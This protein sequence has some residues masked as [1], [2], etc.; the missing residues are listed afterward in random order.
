MKVGVVGNRVGWTRERVFEVLDKE[1]VYRASM[2]ISGGAEG[3]DSFAQDYAKR[4]GV[5]F[6][7]FYPSPNQPIPYRFFNRN[8]N[9]VKALNQKDDFLVAFDKNPGMSGTSNTIHQAQDC[10]RR[11][12]HI[13]K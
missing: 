6:L 4:H 10:K 8:G 5:S 3:V 1:F 11:V 12:I 9:I 13:V 7:V 2:I